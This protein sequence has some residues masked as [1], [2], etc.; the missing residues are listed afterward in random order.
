MKKKR[1][2]AVFIEKKATKRKRGGELVNGRSKQKRL[3]QK[4]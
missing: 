3:Y 2:Y 1:F 4:S